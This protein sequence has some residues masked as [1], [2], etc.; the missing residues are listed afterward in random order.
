MIQKCSTSDFPKNKKP[1]FAPHQVFGFLFM[2]G[3]QVDPE[4]KTSN[5]LVIY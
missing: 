2:F 4:L 3:L 5:V 1:T